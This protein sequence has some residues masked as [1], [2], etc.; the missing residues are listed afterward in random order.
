MITRTGRAWPIGGMPPIEKPGQVVGLA[1]RRA[2]DVGRAGH[3]RQPRE[4]DPVVAGH[5][6]QERLGPSPRGTTKTSDL[7][8]WPSSAPTRGGGLGGGVGRLVED[9]D[10]E[11]HA[12]AGGGVED[13][14]DRGM[15]RGR[16][17][18]A[19]V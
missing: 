3:G 9:G 14:L 6:A 4:V 8:I 16:R 5:E 2:P 10:L 17:A 18:R 19:G 13:A 1:G 12:L 15:E 11:R 7:T